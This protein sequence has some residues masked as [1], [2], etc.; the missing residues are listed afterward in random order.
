MSKAS[1]YLIPI[2]IGII[3]FAF[4]KELLKYYLRMDTLNKESVNESIREMRI[5]IG[6]L[7]L[8][9]IGIVGLILSK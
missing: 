1:L 6:S 2:A 8:I 9:I 3:V 5:I 7:F 4:R